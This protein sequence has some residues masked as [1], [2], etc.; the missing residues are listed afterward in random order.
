MYAF[1]ASAAAAC[2]SRVDA[3][4]D[5]G[6]HG[7]QRDDR[8]HH[9]EQHEAQAI[10]EEKYNVGADIWSVTSYNELYRDGHAAD[11]WNV[12]HPGETPAHILRIPA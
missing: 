2:A 7:G 3:S 1:Q 11:R 5:H 12:L 4:S 9:R 10:L 8:R 6:E